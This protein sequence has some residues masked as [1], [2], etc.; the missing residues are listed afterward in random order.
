MP[1][2]TS[3]ICHCC[4]TATKNAKISLHPAPPWILPRE[5]LPRMTILDAAVTSQ[6]VAVVFPEMQINASSNACLCTLVE[7]APANEMIH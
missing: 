7:I 1:E 4:T 2:I 3:V 5:S 6:D